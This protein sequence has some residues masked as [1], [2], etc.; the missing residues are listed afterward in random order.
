M[1]QKAYSYRFMKSF[2]FLFVAISLLLFADTQASTPKWV[3]NPSIS[4][5]GSTIAFCYQG[6]IFVAKTSNTISTTKQLTT[7]SA[8]DIA[9]IFSRDGKTLVFASNRY[10]NF[11]IYSVSID[12]GTPQR[13]TFHSANEIP[14]DV[15][16]DGQLVLFSSS[17]LDSKDNIL[18]PTPA[19]SELYSVPLQGGRT[20]LVLTTPAEACKVLTNGSLWLYQNRKGYENEWRKH[21]TSSI[22]RDIYSYNSQ[23]K[24]HTKLLTGR[25]EQRDPNFYSLNGTTYIAFLS[26]SDG[27][28]NIWTGQLNAQGAIQGDVKQRTSF[29]QHP[30][31]NLSVSDNGLAIFSWDGELYTL[32]LSKDN[33]SPTKVALDIK[34]DAKVNEQSYKVYTSDATEFE[35]SPTEKE[36]AFIVRGDVF[37]VSLEFKTTKR[38]T[39]TPEQERNVS[40]SPDGRSLLYSSER[41]GSWDVYTSSLPDT[42]DKF[43]YAAATIE[44]KAVISTPAEE[45]QPLFSPDGKY[46]AYLEERVKLR[47]YNVETN[48]SSLLVDSTHNYSYSDGDQYFSWSPDS[49]WIALEFI[50]KKRWVGEV[51]IV[52][53]ET[54]K[55]HN[56]SQSGYNDFA[57]RFMGNGSIFVWFSDRNGMRSHGS[58]GSQSDAYALFLTNKSWEQF[59]LSDVDYELRKEEFNGKDDDDDDD[60]KSKRKKKSE[61]IK[62]KKVVKLVPEFENLDRRYARLTKF[63]S[64][65]GDAILTDDGEKMYYLARFDEGYDLWVTN[66][67]KNENK[68]LAKLKTSSGSLKLS[69]DNKTIYVLANGQLQS[70]N[71]ESG[72]AKP[73]P[74]RA[75]VVLQPAKEREFLFEHVWRQTLKKFYLSSMHGVD[76]N[77]YKN[78]YKK[79]LPEIATTYDFSIMLSELLGELNASHTGCNFRPQF[80]AEVND[81]TASLG[82]FFDR[83][84]NGDGYKIDEIVTGSPIDITAKE[85]RSGDIITHIDGIALTASTDIASLLNKKVGIRTTITVVTKGTKKNF[86]VNPISLGEFSQLLYQRWIDNCEKT[87]LQASNNTIGYVHVRGMNDASFRETFD[88]ALGRHADKKALIVDTRFNGGGWLHDDLATFLSGKQYVSLVP[89]GQQIGSEPQN[90]WQRKSVVLMSEGNYSDAHFF[91]YTYKALGL[92]TLVGMPVPGTA[93]AVWWETLQDP[94]LVFGIPQIGVV[95]TDGKYLEN[96]ELFP[97]IEV[98]ITPEDASNGNDTQLLRAIE[99][100]KK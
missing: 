8:D 72:T 30:T 70:V 93:T 22:A 10:G 90:K 64:A 92:G 50:D 31:R 38:I 40:F 46:I 44:E 65:L 74:F 15:T 71:A 86:I 59:K 75:E 18:F 60:W 89:R 57:P 88:R 25:F 58:W 98:P 80:D 27:V 78:E 5:D 47:L 99:E 81:I 41:N 100:A 56:L 14:T 55:L 3:R 45:F 39:N 87:V 37:V 2:L 62:K 34:V 84:Y 29:K 67:K 48:S 23:T 97:D 83:N 79:F 12:G 94:S 19:L 9:P 24:K 82:C 7:H 63:S 20:S 35:I 49:K 76:W 69:S 32:D 6:D 51:G 21:Q 53:I 1:N 17:Q 68:L 61:L 26:E 16:H 95:G 96:Q 28:F 42:A 52:N 13:L 77:F 54:K 4:H 73:I 91:P 33:N 43:F 66:F 85:I 11:D 36:A